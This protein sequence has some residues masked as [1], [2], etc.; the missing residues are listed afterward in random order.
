MATETQ[1]RERETRHNGE[2]H[3]GAGDDGAKQSNMLDLAQKVEA[4]Y[5]SPSPQATRHAPNV[6]PRMLNYGLLLGII[7]GVGAGLL[8]ALLLQSGRLAPQ[9]WEGLFS[10]SPFTFYAFWAFVG[11]ALGIV[12]GGLI[13]LLMAEPPELPS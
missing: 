12:A 1:Q 2:G 9:G 3:D 13:T 5:T 11:A 8:L 4:H 10:L 6:F 7:L